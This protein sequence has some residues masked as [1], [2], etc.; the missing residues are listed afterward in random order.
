MSEKSLDA[1]ARR[2]ARRVGLELFALP[3]YF[4][5]RRHAKKEGVS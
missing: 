5:E 4:P 3:D 2:A 1:R